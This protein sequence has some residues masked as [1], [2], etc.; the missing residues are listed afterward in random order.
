LYICTGI[1]IIYDEKW[2][3]ILCY[4][5]PCI[6]ALGNSVTLILNLLIPKTARNDVEEPRSTQCE[7]QCNQRFHIIMSLLILVPILC[8]LYFLPNQGCDFCYHWLVF[9]SSHL[10][11]VLG[12]L[13]IFY[14]IIN[15]NLEMHVCMTITVPYIASTCKVT[16]P[17]LW[18]CTHGQWT[19]PFYRHYIIVARYKSVLFS[20]WLSYAADFFIGKKAQNTKIQCLAEKS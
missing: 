10:F 2:S 13:S 12:I 17:F 14:I 9:I 3:G 16:S 11:S 18:A 1:C 7:C 19:Q 20:S 6:F 5:E 15:L 4:H 8:T